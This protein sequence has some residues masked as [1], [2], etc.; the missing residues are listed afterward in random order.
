MSYSS[1]PLRPWTPSEYKDWVVSQIFKDPSICP[2]RSF[3][4]H[5]QPVGPYGCIS[6]IYQAFCRT[7]KPNL[8]R[9]LSVGTLCIVVLPS[10]KDLMVLH[11]ES[12]LLFFAVY[13]RWWMI[14]GSSQLLPASD[15]QSGIWHM[16]AVV[17]MGNVFCLKW[18]KPMAMICHLISSTT[19][20]TPTSRNTHQCGWHNQ[21]VRQEFAFSRPSLEWIAE[22]L[23][24]FSN[25]AEMTKVMLSL[26]DIQLCGVSQI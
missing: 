12:C 3:L 21:T 1:L 11:L 26:L 4:G 25:S 6:I 24:S 16:W 15:S 22:C 17:V 7:N 18:I 5:L 23:H 19:Y 10:I 9:L 20:L 8:S 2:G 14:V 13:I